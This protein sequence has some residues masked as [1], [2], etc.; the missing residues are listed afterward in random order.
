MIALAFAVGAAFQFPTD[1]QA[2]APVAAPGVAVQ[3]EATPTCPLLLRYDFQG[4]AGWAG[5]SWNATLALPPQFA[6][7][8]GLSGQGEPNRLEVKLLQGDNVYWYQRASFRPGPQRLQLTIPSRRLRYAWGPQPEAP[9]TTL[10][11][12]ELVLAAESGG[13]GELCVERAEL[14][15][16]EGPEGL[17]AT[18]EASSHH[19]HHPAPRAQDGD[20]ATYWLSARQPNPTL[21][22]RLA[23][24]TAL[25]GVAVRWGPHPPAS[26]R[27][28][29]AQGPQWQTLPP[30]PPQ[31]GGVTV[32]PLPA[33]SLTAL[34][35]ELVPLP[36]RPVS[37]AEITLEEEGSGDL[38]WAF[39]TLA[40]QAPRGT[41]PRGL[42]GEQ[43]Y[44]TVTGL[45]D[46]ELA[47]PVSEDGA[48]ELDLAGVTLEPMVR[49]EGRLLTWADAVVTRDLDEGHLPL[50]RVRWQSGE[51]EA[52]WQVRVVR[53]RGREAVLWEGELTHTGHRPVAGELL[54]LVRPLRVTPPWATLNLPPVTTPIPSLAARGAQLRVGE[55]WVVAAQAEGTWRVTDFARGE[56]GLW[57]R[58][59]RLP[60]ESSVTD[61]AGAASAVLPVP[62]RLQPRERQAVR[63]FVSPEDELPG[64]V[65]SA[66][67]PT[68]WEHAA[69]AWRRALAGVSLVVPAPAGELTATV[70]AN[71]A[72]MLLHRQGA[73]LYPGSRHYARAWIRD[74]YG[75]G[76]ALLRT[77]HASAVRDFLTFYANFQFPDGQIPCCVDRRG[78]DPVPEHDSH[79]QFLALLAAYTTHSGETTTALSL[80]RRVEATV[81]AI[82]RLRET[83]R[84]EAFRHGDK[85]RFFGLL[86]ASI[87]HEGYAAHPVHS[88]WDDLWALR[89]L[90]D[91]AHLA[92]QLGF[93]EQAARWEAEA[94]GLASDL[95]TS[96]LLVQRE[97]GVPH[98]PASAELADFDPTSSA[99]AWNLDLVRHGFAELP[100]RTTFERYLHNLGTR[101]EGREWVDYTPYEARIASAL[102]RMG[103]R[104]EAWRLLH[105]LLADRRPEGWL[106]WP[107]VITRD[108]RAAR[109]VGDMPHAWVGAEFVNAVL[110]AVAY[111][112]GERLVVAAGIPQAWLQP[113][114]QVQVGPLA[115]PWGW[116]EVC[117]RGE[118]DRL[119][120]Q[121]SGATPPGGV[122]LAW[123][124]GTRVRVDGLPSPRSGDGVVLLRLPAEVEIQR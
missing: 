9:L 86:P 97:A 34:R 61:P 78:A 22:L 101:L 52:R 36:N 29:L 21:T 65:F 28:A 45:P 124:W 66:R 69:A 103:W 82:G 50:P 19:P 15:P 94:E 77:G 74:A 119:V 70:H 26:F 30:Q 59:G 56:V 95:R 90:A 18:V 48:V 23:A 76:L 47:V 32:L 24:P 64:E 116:F 53:H 55:R 106:T 44:W 16:Q 63:V 3:V 27:L 14:R 6:L 10:T 67:W 114:A 39:R 80:W 108:P 122:F 1:P 83:R 12:L 85:L 58:A 96:M 38:T 54:L 60:T 13:R 84:G 20:P 62:F 92:R 91:A 107:E 68:L 46:G 88:Y 72:F 98:V 7:H 81:A 79:G 109:F 113:G 71:L 104:Q 87:S 75:I 31:P 43:V 118:E 5:L 35:L 17:S 8:L 49:V 102:I 123:P 51:L 2:V 37:V 105:A 121:L 11:A 40:A 73:A 99:I 120:F 110:D 100:W 112:E 42:A 57:V 33:E 111:P 41:F 115:T 4:V 93:L 117:A 89:G 25:A